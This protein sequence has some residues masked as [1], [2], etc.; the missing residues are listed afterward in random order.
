MKRLMTGNEACGEASIR[1]GC[2][3]YFGY[4]ITPQSEIP[5]YMSRELPKRGKIFIQAHSEIEAINMLY[6]ASATGKRAMTSSSSPGISLK[7]EGISYQAG[8]ELP[9]VII[10]VVRGGPGLGNIAPSQEDYFLVLKIESL[11]LL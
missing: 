2:Y 5:E 6:G 9:V 8:A 7:Q 1:A 11:I 4:P 3:S 10:D